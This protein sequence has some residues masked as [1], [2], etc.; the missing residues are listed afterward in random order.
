MSVWRLPHPLRDAVPD[1]LARDVEDLVGRVEALKRSGRVVVFTNGAFDL[2]HA[3]H[4]RSL[5]HARALGDHLIVA[6]NSDA[7]VRRIKGPPRPFFPENERVEL[8][9]CLEPVD[10][11]FLFDD[12][13]ADRL[14][15]LLKPDIHAKGPDYSPETVPERATVASYGGR[16][17]I[18]GDRKDHSSSEIFRRLCELRREGGRRP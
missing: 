13:T 2:L 18:V 12:D 10:T 15:A 16:V 1:K 4:V 3:G 6:V 14:L 5:R 9:A 7:S 11:V 8:V 17:M